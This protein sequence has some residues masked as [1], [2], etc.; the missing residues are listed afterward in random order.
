[1]F[2]VQAQRYN[3]S[4]LI[5]TV[6]AFVDESNVVEESQFLKECANLDDSEIV[7]GIVSQDVYEILNHAYPTM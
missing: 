2:Y 1:M 6:P 4:L 7:Q 3:G 5:D